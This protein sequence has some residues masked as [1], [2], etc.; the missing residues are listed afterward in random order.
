MSSA[1]GFGTIRLAIKHAWGESFITVE[2]KPPCPFHVFRRRRGKSLFPWQ[3]NWLSLSQEWGR[4]GKVERREGRGAGVWAGG[5]SGGMTLL[6][7]LHL[8]S[9]GTC[10]IGFL[11]SW[12][13]KCDWYFLMKQ[14]RGRSP[15][16][17]IRQLNFS[18][19][20]LTI[21]HCSHGSVSRH[22]PGSCSDVLS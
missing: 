2:T 13:G 17:K 10:H 11:L 15:E 12:R 19:L 18:L 8:T 22:D 20:S 7:D 9:R 21:A 6:T 14:R 3:P 16:L 5:M 1:V 4:K